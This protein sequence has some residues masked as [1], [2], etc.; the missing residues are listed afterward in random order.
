MENSS[1]R[2]TLSHNPSSVELPSSSIDQQSL[3]KSVAVKAK[4]F[5]DSETAS[6]S[7][8]PSQKSLPRSIKVSTDLQSCSFTI[9]S[10]DSENFQPRTSSPRGPI[11]SDIVK[12]LTQKTENKLNSDT[13]SEIS[14]AKSNDT[15][16]VE[17]N[18]M[19]PSSTSSQ[20]SP[21]S[22]SSSS[23]TTT[24]VSVRTPTP[25]NSVCQI[26]TAQI[27]SIQPMIDSVTQKV[28]T[29][30]DI[31][32]KLAKECESSK[33]SG[34][35][36][37]KVPKQISST[38]T[39][40]P[41]SK[42]TTKLKR[43]LS[44]VK[45]KRD[46]APSKEELEDPLLNLSRNSTDTDSPLPT[47]NFAPISSV[48]TT[49]L[50]GDTENV[51]K[52]VI[53]KKEDV[54]KLESDRIENLIPV[55]SDSDVKNSEITPKTS[56]ESPRLSVTNSK[57]ASLKGARTATPQ[58]ST[59]TTR[60]MEL[61]KQKAQ[62]AEQK[63]QLAANKRKSM[64]NRQS[65]TFKAPS[66][67][68]SSTTGISDLGT[69]NS[70]TTANSAVRT[71]KRAS[72][73][74]EKPRTTKTNKN[75]PKN[76][77]SRS[78]SG[79]RE[80]I[81]ASLESV[82]YVGRS[83]SSVGTK[84]VRK[85]REQA[86]NG[87]TN[88]RKSTS[89]G[90]SLPGKNGTDLSA[91]RVRI[92]STGSSS[93]QGT[94]RKSS[95]RQTSSSNLKLTS[96]KSKTASNT[97][98]NKKIALM[99]REFTKNLVKLSTNSM[100]ET[101]PASV[102]SSTSTNQTSIITGSS[103]TTTSSNT[104]TSNSLTTSASFDSVNVLLTSLA[105]TSLAPTSL[106]Q[107]SLAPTS[108][109]ASSNHLD[110][111]Q[112]RYEHY[113]QQKLKIEAAEQ[114]ASQ[115]QNS[116]NSENQNID[117]VSLYGMHV[118]TTE[119]VRL[120]ERIRDRVGGSGSGVGQNGQT[121]NSGKSIESGNSLLKGVIDNLYEIEDALRATDASLYSNESFLNETNTSMTHTS[122]NFTSNNYHFN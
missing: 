19:R 23:S 79:S 86:G 40:I 46:T 63:R 26:E 70:I 112:S 1:P 104:L 38:S 11:V 100:T 121:N 98:F 65:V 122:N 107:T 87:K 62:E 20:T 83:A 118:L 120:S 21:T 75:P 90:L 54:V 49:I 50:M 55:I 35:I 27:P 9:I 81:D 58:T 78:Q 10:P 110:D 52:Y 85:A 17:R 34:K 99:S 101:M 64:T 13:S 97:D 36:S 106:A 111:Y 45:P 67:S 16:T 51:V 2:P 12:E 114:Q 93:V 73:P 61:R 71:S 80:T 4:T 60:T 56:I 57:R 18:V 5:Y 22:G 6:E 44:F 72:H 109:A 74:P 94:P 96:N 28:D 37:A 25:T 89:M 84:I 113:K 42:N 3:I 30:V 29:A 68:A 48:S 92:K 24:S 88:V 91:Q 66:T 77:Y 41:N 39:K 33:T 103:Q 117:R 8:Q 32:T 31:S 116:Q 119:L 115:A 105:P 7:T 76:G 47:S 15:Y 53:K 69:I 102:Y 59:R 108:L 82:E 14:P 43:N 95:S